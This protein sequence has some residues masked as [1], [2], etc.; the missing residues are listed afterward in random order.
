[1]LSYLESS[2]SAVCY[3]LC[4]FKVF[5]KLPINLQLSFL[6]SLSIPS[7]KIRCRTS[8]PVH[9]LSERGWIYTLSQYGFN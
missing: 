2:H 4:L 7:T 6:D 9:G 5:Q 8:M 1:M 3:N